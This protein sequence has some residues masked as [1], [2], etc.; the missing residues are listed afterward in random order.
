MGSKLQVS[1]D[2]LI[3]IINHWDFDATPI[4]VGVMGPQG[5]G[6]SYLSSHLSAS[7]TDLYPHLHTITISSDDLY[8]THEKQLSL[9][10]DYPNNQLITSG[11]GLPGTHDIPLLKDIFSKVIERNTNY[12]IPTYDKSKNQGKGDRSSTDQWIRIGDRPVDILIFEGWFNGFLPINDRN[13][14]YQKWETSELLNKLDFENEIVL[15]DGLLNDYVDLWHNFNCFIYFD[16]E[17]LEYVYKWRIQQEHELIQ[18]KGIG[19]TDSQVRKFVDRYIP[20]YLLYY[21]QLKR[22]GFSNPHLQTNVLFKDNLKI[23]LGPER[24]IIRFKTFSS[25]RSK[26]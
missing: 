1:L 23:S 14:L 20:V 21:D 8:L 17:D 18:I 22:N 11:R 3:P 24:D 16:V 12:S 6:K 26:F 4:I 19:M 5:S 25:L 10:N 15:I 7:L 9:I 13:A 2:Y